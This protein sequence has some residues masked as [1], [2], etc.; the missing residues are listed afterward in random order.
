MI[1]VFGS[2]NIDLVTRAER[3]PAPGETVLGGDYVAIPGGKGA[4]QALAA[5]RA[6][7]EVALI[8]AYG[9]DGFA[10]TAISL[11]RADGVD[12]SAC[13]AVDKP[14]GVAFITVDPQGENAI[15]VASGANA[16]ARASQLEAS[17][18]TTR[19]ILLLQREVP[20]AEMEAAAG[21]G[22]AARASCSTRRPPARSPRNCWPISTISSSTSTKRLSSAPGSTF[23]ATRRPS[24][25]KS[26]R[27]TASPPSSRWARPAR[28][29]SPR[30]GAFRRRRPR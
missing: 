27:A 5:R 23:P 1:V 8:G 11:L 20:I 21:R 19:D 3:I 15:V 6:G 13:R 16:E 17:T 28:W 26:T 14:T 18:L 2:I 9:A 24:P 7:A 10:E 12:L 30:G 22:G 4:N 25:P 29:P